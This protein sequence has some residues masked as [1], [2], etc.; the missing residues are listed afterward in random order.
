LFKPVEVVD[1]GAMARDESYIVSTATGGPASAESDQ[2]S[3]V[4]W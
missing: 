2:L 1:V 3:E 4:R